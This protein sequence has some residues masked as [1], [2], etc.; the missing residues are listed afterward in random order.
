MVQRHMVRDLAAG[1]PGGLE[2]LIEPIRARCGPALRAVVLYGS[3][4]RNANVRDG[5]V[6]LMAVVEDYRSVHGIGLTALLNHLLP[7]NVYYLEAGAV[8]DRVRCKFIIVSE[9]SFRK[10]TAGGLDGYF[11]ARFTQ[12][13]RLVWR[14]DDAAIAFI[15]ECRAR[16]A[17]H[18]ATEAVR[19]GN[20]ALTAGDFWS[21]ALSAT[22]GCELRPEP[23]G[24]A[25]ALI[26][27]DPEFWEGLSH[28][29]LPAL[30][31]VTKDDGLYRIALAGR[32]RFAGRARWALRRVWSKSLNF[33]RLVKAAGTFANGIDY[34]SWKIERHSGV[35]V[36]VTDAMRRHPRLASWKL[37]FRMWRN[38]VLG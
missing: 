32:R 30:D 21:R 28:A 14:A 22:Y 34:L 16:A 6:D 15:A 13:C 7:P 11:W 27:R 3:T 5:L 25:R 35:K 31:G 23:P 36:E 17:V 18:F 24:A 20:G 19:L 12:P 1:A 9:R 8:G 10:R 29:V 4:R 2:P 33:M 38:G 37:L 26:E